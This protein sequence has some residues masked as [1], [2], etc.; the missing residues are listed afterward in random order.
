MKKYKLIT[1]DH[2]TRVGE[3]NETTWELGQWVK[4]VGE[5]ATLCSDGYLHCYDDPHLALLLNPLHA[6]IK[7]PIVCMV[8]V[9]GES[10][11]SGSMKSGFK[12]MRVTEYLSTTVTLTQRVAFSI[13]CA[14]RVYNSP[15]FTEWAN[16]WL[17]GRDGSANAAEEAVWSVRSAEAAQAARSAA[18]AAARA[19]A[20][21]AA[22]AAAWAAEAAAEAAT[23]AASETTWAA[24]A[25]ARAAAQTAVWAARSVETIWTAAGSAETAGTAAEAAAETAAEAAAA[26]AVWSAET[27]ETVNLVA[28]TKKALKY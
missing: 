7:N 6:D 13:F 14:L 25:A 8:E 9:R 24:R 2:K 10:R 19:A 22:Q 12:E 17:S 28:I 21:A 27:A 23:R 11:K 26:T 18:W 20:E 15:G 16:N 4:A 1:Q 5:G 3:P